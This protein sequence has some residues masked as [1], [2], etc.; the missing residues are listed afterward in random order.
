[1]VEVKIQKIFNVDNSYVIEHLEGFIREIA[2]NYIAGNL[3][4]ELLNEVSIDKLCRQYYWNKFNK[5]GQV[6]FTHEEVY[7]HNMNNGRK[8]FKDSCYAKIDWIVYIDVLDKLIDVCTVL[9]SSLHMQNP[10]IDEEVK[11]DLMYSIMIRELLQ[12]TVNEESDEE[13]QKDKV[14]GENDQKRLNP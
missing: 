11:K 7:K 5:T 9:S 10:M 4:N 6:V 14:T 2:Y 12:E 3:H 13:D 8:R 1:M